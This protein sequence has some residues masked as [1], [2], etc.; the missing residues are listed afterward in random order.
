MQ[1]TVELLLILLVVFVI[2]IILMDL[3][4]SA[5]FLGTVLIVIKKYVLHTNQLSQNVLDLIM[6]SVIEHQL[7]ANVFLHGL[8]LYVI[9][10][11]ETVFLPVSTV[12]VIN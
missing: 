3:C 5:I 12:F 1:L 9:S 8:V 7:L 2:N 11:L 6:E 10:Y 4:A